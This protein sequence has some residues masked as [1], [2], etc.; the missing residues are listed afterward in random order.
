M[1][2]GVLLAFFYRPALL[3]VDS[4]GTIS[5]AVAAACIVASSNYVLNELLDGPGDRSHPEKRNRPVPSGQINP[6]AG[7][8]EWLLL[9]VAGMGLAWM[10]GPAFAASALMLWVMGVAYNVPPVRLKEWPYQYPAKHLKYLSSNLF[11]HQLH[12]LKKDLK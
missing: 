4:L 5:I 1:L 6:A 7:Y 11:F 12:M 10:V 2:L 9:A 8:V 3:T